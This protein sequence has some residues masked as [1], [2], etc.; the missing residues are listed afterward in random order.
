VK[1]AGKG[2]SEA[3]RKTKLLHEK[4]GEVKAEIIERDGQVW[5][6]KD[7]PQHGLTED[8]MAIDVVL[9]DDKNFQ[10][11]I[12]PYNDE[13]LHNHGTSTIKHDEVRF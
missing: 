10:A 7:C 4:V 9:K 1:E 2:L 5:M 8:L 3:S 11:V 6:V 12:F 13:G